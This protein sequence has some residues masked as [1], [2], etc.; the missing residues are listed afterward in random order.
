L[1]SIVV[2]GGLILFSAFLLHDTQRVIKM[3]EGYPVNHF[4]VSQHQLTYGAPRQYDPINAYD[5][6]ENPL[7]L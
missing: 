3:A 7:S 5:L 1:A 4:G 2:Y 6:E